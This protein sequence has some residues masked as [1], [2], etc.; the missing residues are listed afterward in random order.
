VVTN[1]KWE[2]LRSHDNPEVSGIFPGFSWS[3]EMQSAS[4]DPRSPFVPFMGPGLGQRSRASVLGMSGRIRAQESLAASPGPGEFVPR[5]PNFGVSHLVPTCSPVFHSRCGPARRI[6]SGTATSSV[7]S[8]IGLVCAPDKIRKSARSGSSP[9]RLLC[10]LIFKKGRAWPSAAYGV[11][12]RE[13]RIKL[14][15]V[16]WGRQKSENC[17]ASPG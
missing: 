9:S 13:I 10:A 8:V 7:R 3:G 2:A 15:L 12:E 5:R 4:D 17:P 1:A 14:R 6:T 11:V 16:S